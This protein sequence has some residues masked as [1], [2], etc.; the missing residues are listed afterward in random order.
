MWNVLVASPMLRSTHR[1]RALHPGS[2]LSLLRPSRPPRL[3]QRRSGGRPEPPAAV[4]TLVP[5]RVAQRQGEDE[6]RLER[7]SHQ[8]DGRRRRAGDAAPPLPPRYSP[9][10][11][12]SPLG[13]RRASR[14]RLTLPSVPQSPPAPSPAPPS[15]SSATS[16]PSPCASPPCSHHPPAAHR[17]PLSSLPTL[18]ARPSGN[19]PQMAASTAGNC[20]IAAGTFFLLQEG[21]RLIRQADDPSNSLLA[22]A[23][24]G[25]LLMRVARGPAY[26]AA[27]AAAVGAAGAAGH[28]LV[29]VYAD[30]RLGRAAGDA[31]QART[32]DGSPAPDTHAAALVLLCVACVGVA[33]RLTPRSPRPVLSCPGGRRFSARRRSFPTTSG[34]STGRSSPCG[35]R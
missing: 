34:P 21:C 10:G 30:G 9:A 25:A 2:L 11:S 16:P 13:P 19:N 4:R 18:L 15:R 27:G 7:A 35:S 26:A 33:P 23:A 31:S 28:A 8:P 6:P 29:D 20:G 1:R 3:L 17:P 12:F 14:G 24:T 5:A 32:Q 22:G